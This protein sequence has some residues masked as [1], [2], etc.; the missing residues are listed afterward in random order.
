MSQ[1]DLIPS[2]NILPFPQARVHKAEVEAHKDSRANRQA[3]KVVD[4][5]PGFTLDGH[6]PVRGYLVARLYSDEKEPTANLYRGRA[7]RRLSDEGHSRASKAPNSSAPVLRSGLRAFG[8]LSLAVLLPILVL[9]ALLWLGQTNDTSSRPVMPLTGP[10]QAAQATI[11]LPVL[12]APTT[13][14]AFAGQRTRFPIAIKGS[15]PV[16]GDTILISRLPPGSAFSAGAAQGQTS[17]RLKPGE[18]DDLLLVLP[19]GIH[20]EVALMIQLLAPGGHVISDTATIVDV[21]GAPE[22]KILVHRVKTEVIP[23]RTW[24]QPRE[25][26][27][28]DT[29]AKADLTD[30]VS[31]APRS[32]PVPL[33]ARRPSSAR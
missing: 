1:P 27:G 16:T 26:S 19:R 5:P 4:L 23:G 12:S 25:K 10:A 28:A 15:K 7:R 8:I 24:E 18:V 3:L 6:G 17:W 13:L 11:L 30:S 9:G 20:N 22:E 21:T 33:P 32:D 29:G 14:K 31:E 2:D